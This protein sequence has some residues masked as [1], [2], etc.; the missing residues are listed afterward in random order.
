MGGGRPEVWGQAGPGAAAAGGGDWGPAGRAG[1]ARLQ[2]DSLVHAGLVAWHRVKRVASLQEQ[3]CQLVGQGPVSELRSRA[4]G[5]R[6]CPRVP[7]P[8][9]RGRA[10]DGLG[11]WRG[12]WL[13]SVPAA[14]SPP[15]GTEAGQGQVGPGRGSPGSPPRRRPAAGWAPPRRTAAPGR[16]RPW[17]AAAGRVAPA[18]G[19][20]SRW[21]P[22]QAPPPGA[23]GHA[24][25]TGAHV[26]ASPPRPVRLEGRGPGAWIASETTPRL[27]GR[28]P[29]TML[30]VPSSAWHLH[31][32]QPCPRTREAGVW[33]RGPAPL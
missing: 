15:R 24:L 3:P 16:S 30:P 29:V 25:S 12:L 5:R 18:W 21:V 7:A 32:G 1:G 11:G 28:P 10:R 19:R 4:R 27:T 9:R 22:A 31:S 33:V 13:T 14:G 23:Q 8:S 20:D 2:E 26:T 17:A 6:L